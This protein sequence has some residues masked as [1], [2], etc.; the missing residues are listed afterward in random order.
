MAQLNDQKDNNEQDE[1]QIPNVVKIDRE[2][3]VVFHQLKFGT[4]FA[5][6]LVDTDEYDEGLVLDV[7]KSPPKQTTI[8]TQ[9]KKFKISSFGT[10]EQIFKDLKKLTFLDLNEMR[11]FS[12]QHHAMYQYT[13]NTDKLIAKNSNCDSIMLYFVYVPSI[14]PITSNIINI[15]LK[16]DN[17]SLM[18]SININH[19]VIELKTALYQKFNILP[20]QQLLILNNKNMLNDELVLSDFKIMENDTIQ[21][22][23]LANN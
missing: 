16:I 23:I 18:Y 20:K 5:S 4:I 6:N 14:N 11:L 15:K 21:V 22:M 19:T 10:L 12:P 3:N 9:V 13:D 8:A 7:V 1:K 2:V 17:E